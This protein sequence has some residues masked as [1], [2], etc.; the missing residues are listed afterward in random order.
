MKRSRSFKKAFPPRFYTPGVS[1][2]TLNYIINLRQKFSSEP[3]L[4]LETNQ[5]HYAGSIPAYGLPCI[6]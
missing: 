5:G 3:C 4:T 2:E 1:D 6:R